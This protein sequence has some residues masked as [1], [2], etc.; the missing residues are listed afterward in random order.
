[1]APLV[2]RKAIHKATVGAFL[3]CGKIRATTR[4]WALAKSDDAVTCKNCLKRMA[5]AASLKK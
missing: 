1:M 3:A 4:G 5:F 2:R